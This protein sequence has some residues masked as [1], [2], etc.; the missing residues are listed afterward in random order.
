MTSILAG[1]AFAIAAIGIYGVVA[2]TE[3]A[4][5]REFGL[6]NERTPNNPPEAVLF[7]AVGGGATSSRGDRP[8]DS[9]N[10]S[11]VSVRS[12]VEGLRNCIQFTLVRAPHQTTPNDR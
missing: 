1:L 5:T 7:A 3:A 9:C 8:D 12:P 11:D 4:R 10:R 2:Y 6:P